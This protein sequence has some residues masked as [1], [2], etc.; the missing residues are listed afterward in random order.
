VEVGVEDGS[1]SEVSLNDSRHLDPSGLG[2]DH[3]LPLIGPI[4][5]LGL[6]K[7]KG[8]EP[9]RAINGEDNEQILYG[10]ARVI[11]IEVG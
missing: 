10:L 11:P 5:F 2:D 6:G 9:D 1:R 8:H 3:L 4:A 7:T